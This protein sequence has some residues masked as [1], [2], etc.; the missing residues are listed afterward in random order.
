[1]HRRNFGWIILFLLPTSA[2]FC[3]FYLVPLFSV[4]TASFFE[5]N[6]FDEWK[7]IGWQNYRMISADGTFRTALMNTMLWALIAVGVHVPFGIWV[8]LVLTRKPPGWKFVRSVSMLPAI[9]SPAALS[10]LY[11]FLFNPGV[12]LLNSS[13]ELVGL[14]HWQMN[15]FYDARTAFWSITATWV[16]Y[17]G[18]IVLITMAELFS[19][20]PSL[21]EAATIDGATQTQIS[22]HIRLPLIKNIIGTGMIM[23]IT[24]SYKMFEVIYLTTAGGPQDKTTNLS[25]LI[26]SEIVQKSRY[27]YANA[28]SVLLIVLGVLCIVLVSKSLNMRQGAYE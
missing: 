17:V 5:W 16:F 22:F 1:M 27:G 9:V 23:A 14:G 18:V 21:E 12:G 24:G 28:V 3:V 15:W 7:Y 4:A 13:L 11:L 10:V 25:F 6:G 26:F 20:D 2:L 19:L 8:A